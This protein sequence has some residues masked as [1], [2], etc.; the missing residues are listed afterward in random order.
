[1]H[2]AT[3]I[4]TPRLKLRQWRQGD[5]EPFAR[6]N[7]D[8]AVMRY[9][10]RPLDRAASDLSMTTWQAD[11]A[12]QGWGHW[13]VETLADD[14]FIGFVGLSVPRRALPFMPCVELGYRLARTHW[15]QGLATEA[16][17]AALDFGF[18]QLGLAEVVAFT[19]LVNR[20]SR[21]VMARLGMHDAGEDFDHPAVAEG[22]ALR[23]H[24]LYRV[25]RDQWATR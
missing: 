15:G 5:R 16:A 19:A 14:C 9:F 2:T 7:A 10:P 8:P 23:R 11:I 6:L 3:E 1:M 4:V 18:R 22:S 24:C 21:A 12:R 17:S 20:P 13:A 25:T